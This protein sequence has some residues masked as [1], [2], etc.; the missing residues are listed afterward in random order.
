MS[1]ILKM[2][3]DLQKEI[4]KVSANDLVYSSMGKRCIHNRD[5]SWK[6]THTIVTTTTLQEKIE[7]TVMDNRLIYILSHLY[8][9][10]EFCFVFGCFNDMSKNITF[11]ECRCHWSINEDN[12]KKL[13]KKK[14]F[15]LLVMMLEGCCS[16]KFATIILVRLNFLLLWYVCTSFVLSTLLCG[17]HRL[18]SWGTN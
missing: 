6:R 4:R 1:R 10:I 5:K 2:K 18:I 17:N 7:I 9:F 11:T 12:T 8:I 15:G 3:E 14:Q 16:C 13:C